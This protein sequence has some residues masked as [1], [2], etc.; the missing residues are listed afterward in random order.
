MMNTDLTSFL[1]SK[2]VKGREDW[3]QAQLSTELSLV[4]GCA[5]A[6]P[7]SERA[8]LVALLE[9]SCAFADTNRTT[10]LIISS[11]AQA[12]LNLKLSFFLGIN[13]VLFE[14]LLKALKKLT[15]LAFI[16]CLLTVLACHL[17]ENTFPT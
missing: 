7:L 3:P 1:C 8:E 13:S 14:Q 16:S 2:K 12:G 9:Q 11:R 17:Q 10:T 15:L 4:Q 6:T 5:P